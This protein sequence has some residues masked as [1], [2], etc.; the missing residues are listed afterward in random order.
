MQDRREFSLS[1]IFPQ[2]RSGKIMRRV[3]RDIAEGREP[4][5]LSTLVDRAAVDELVNETK[6]RK[7]AGAAV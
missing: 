6:K 3:L 1:G 4:G 7:A 2:T 5:D